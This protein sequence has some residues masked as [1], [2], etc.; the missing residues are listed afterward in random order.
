[1]ELVRESG[2][3]RRRFLDLLG[4]Q[5]SAEYLQLLRE[6]QR[7]LK[8]RNETLSRGFVHARTRAGAALAREPWTALVVTAGADLAA[9][10]A[11]LVT[12]IAAA[13]AG[14]TTEAF[15]APLGIAYSPSVPWD[16]EDGAAAALGAALANSTG[17]DEALGYTTLGPHADDLELTLGG[18]DL[19][20]YGSLGQQQ[21]AA[22]FLKLAQADLVRRTVGTP[23]ILLVD[24]M[25]AVLDRRAAEEFL[26]QVE[27]EGQIFLATAQEGWLGEL[28]S[29]R[30]LVHRVAAGSV[31]HE[32][33]SPAAS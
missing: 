2:R 19:R 8:Q 27:G 10:R 24:E 29:R 32:S 5:L 23:P 26:R 9:R 13:Q 12:D 11:R 28:R 20:R 6:Y 21:L 33:A 17:K 4:C 15:P 3:V 30:F 14:L 1:V 16:G 22:M 7:A 18:R 31:E 25:F